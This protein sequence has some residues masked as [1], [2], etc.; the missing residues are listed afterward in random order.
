MGERN[1]IEQQ[2]LL[3]AERDGMEAFV[4]GA[5]IDANPFAAGTPFHAAW[6]RG[7]NEARAHHDR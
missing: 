1:I 3:F 5:A 4:A 7:W 6:L 2:D